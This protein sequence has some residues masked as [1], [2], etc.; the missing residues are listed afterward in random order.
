[1]FRD[2]GRG[3]PAVVVWSNRSLMNNV[4][5]GCYTSGIP[6]GIVEIWTWRRDTTCVRQSN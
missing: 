3:M 5:C 2:D 1:M 4:N 6:L